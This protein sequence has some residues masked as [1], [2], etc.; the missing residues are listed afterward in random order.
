MVVSGGCNPPAFRLAVRFRH[1]P[2]I[3]YGDMILD[4]LICFSVIS[5]AWLSRLLWEQK[6]TGSNPVSPTKEIRRCS[7]TF[8]TPGIK[9]RVIVGANPTDGA[10]LKM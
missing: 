5:E 1:S 6:I 9:G 7:L 4:N 10:K 8:K 2:P 3:T